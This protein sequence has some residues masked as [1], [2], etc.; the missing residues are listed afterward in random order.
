[1]SARG[2][3]SVYGLLGSAPTVAPPVISPPGATFTGSQTVT[4]TDATPGAQIFYTTDGSTP[5]VNSK[6]YNSAKAIS[7]TSNETI[8]AIA[9]ATGYLQGAPV[10]AVF[11]STANAAN[12]SFPWPAEPTPGRSP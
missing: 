6:L 2:G 10:S 7:V 12:P 9:S 4:I 1:M 11:S 3:L 8:T 5:T